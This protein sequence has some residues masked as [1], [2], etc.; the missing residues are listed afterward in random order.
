[1]LRVFHTKHRLHLTLHC[2]SVWQPSILP[3][4]KLYSCSLSLCR[5]F[6]KYIIW[7]NATVAPFTASC[8]FMHKNVMMNW[9]FTTGE[10]LGRRCYWNWHRDKNVLGICL[11]HSWLSVLWIIDVNPL[12]A[13]I[14]WEH[15]YLKLNIF[16][17]IS[18]FSGI[19]RAPASNDS[20]WESPSLSSLLP[21]TCTTSIAA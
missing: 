11:M 9:S 16:Q 18:I 8:L 14:W 12:T 2:L 21:H 15:W 4:L 7:K 10:Y 1:M 6:E 3:A 13:S 19:G 20:Q 17:Q 5:N